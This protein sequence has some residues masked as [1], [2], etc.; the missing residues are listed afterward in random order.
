MGECVVGRV[1]GKFSREPVKVEECQN[2]VE[3]SANSG[4]T[5]G[6]VSVNYF[7]PSLACARKHIG[8]NSLGTCGP[9]KNKTAL[10]GSI[11]S[12]SCILLTWRVALQRSTDTD[13][14]HLLS[15]RHVRRARRISRRM[16]NMPL[17]P[18][19][20]GAT[21]CTHPVDRIRRR[22]SPRPRTQ[23]VA[24]NLNAYVRLWSTSVS[25]KLTL[26]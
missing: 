25:N 12:A 19:W 26:H 2:R 4:F 11:T 3:R 22:P 10:S 23:M 24:V 5:G 1:I 20:G 9:P 18:T 13:T 21:C 6:L 14:T 8:E 17:A 16:R 15:T 7:C